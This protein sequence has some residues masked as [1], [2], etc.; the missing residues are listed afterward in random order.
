MTLEATENEF[1]ELGGHG[2]SLVP[3]Q[4][5]S[6]GTARFSSGQVT[7]ER[8]PSTLERSTIADLVKEDSDTRRD[9]GGEGRCRRGAQQS[10]SDQKESECARG[11]A[12]VRASRT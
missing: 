5:P 12:V 2:T 8:A 1:H 9:G 7:S 10:R 3:P 6:R 11:G 4:Q